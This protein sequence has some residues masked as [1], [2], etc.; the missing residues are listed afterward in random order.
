MTENGARMEVRAGAGMSGVGTGVSVRLGGAIGGDDALAMS[1]SHLL[2]C[3]VERVYLASDLLVLALSTTYIPL[4]RI[5]Y[6]LLTVFLSGKI[7]GI[8]QRAKFSKKE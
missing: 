6:S 3:R 7:I 5:G 1:I 8:I 4:R 2:G